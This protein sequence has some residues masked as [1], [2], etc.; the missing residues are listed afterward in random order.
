MLKGESDLPADTAI[1]KYLSIEAFL[2]LI[3]F[4]RLTFS[5]ITN[6]SDAYEGS[7]FEFFKKAKNDQQFSKKR[8]DDFYACCWTL[9]TEDLCL[10]ENT[11][12]HKKALEELQ[13]SGSA[14]MWEGYCKNGGVRVKT[15]LGKMDALLQNKLKNS[16]IF[17]MFRGRV[18]YEPS[19]SWD[20]TSKISDLIST[21]FM[22]RVPF[23]H[24][25]EYRYILVLNETVKEPVIS[26]MIDDLYNFFDEILISP[27]TNSKKWIT[28]TLYNISVGIS[29]NP[30]RSGTNSK[31]GN[32]FCKIS[33]L[34]GSISE[35]IGHYDMS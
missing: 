9:Q 6:W 14:S 19:T 35:T 12:E 30:E 5:R 34:Y 21:L 1:Y 10:Y 4:Q 31:N 23:R 17:K 29:I 3:K 2:Y 25:A 11:D 22:K 15:T 26:V 33:Q 7:R 20:K 32:Q 13:R 28:R 24:E 16:D 18:Y 27:A 8:K